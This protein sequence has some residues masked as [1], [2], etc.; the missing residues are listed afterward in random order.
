MKKQLRLV[1]LGLILLCACRKEEAVDAI[2]SST[3]TE[4]IRAVDISSYPEIAETNPTFFDTQQ[5][6]KSFLAIL[7]ENGVNTIRLR[8]WV[9]PANVNSSFDEVNQFAQTLKASGFRIW[10]T[11]HYSDTWADPAHQTTPATWQG[12]SISELKDSVFEYTR[13]VVQTINPDYIQIGNEINSGFL[14]PY[15]DININAPDFVN[16]LQAGCNAVRQYAP[17]C[18]I[19][20]HVAGFKD[21][22]WFY[23]QVKSVDYDIIGLSYYP[24]WHGKSVQALKS[25]M[26][27]LNAHYHKQVVVAETAYPFTLGWNDWTNNIVGLNEHLILPDFPATPQGQFQF[28]EQLKSMTQELN[29][30]LGLCYWGA[31]LIAWKGAQDTTGSSWENQALFNFSNQA[32]PALSAFKE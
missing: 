11:L 27:A 15:G 8:L 21:A 17:Q 9:N 32:L 20:L 31:E 4:F 5:Q 25:S 1:T 14:H 29:G 30:G 16:L 10:L 18:K 2:T 19:I 3:Q 24:I 7:K 28:V 13:N 23:N 22:D 26:N 6:P 12:V